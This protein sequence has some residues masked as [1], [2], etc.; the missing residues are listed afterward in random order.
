MKKWIVALVAL[1]LA[2]C[3]SSV[4]INEED[5]K[6]IALDAAGYTESE[7][8]DLQVSEDNGYV[9]KYSSDGGDYQ[10]V[11]NDHGI[12]QKRNVKSYTSI[13]SEDVIER[14]SEVVE[15][16]ETLDEETKSKAIEIALNNL[17]LQESQVENISVEE[18]DDSISVKFTIIANKN[19]LET[20]INMTTGSA[21]SSYINE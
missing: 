12:I 16:E 18:K 10:F 19:R 11:I 21:V 13:D 7:V 3:Q 9:V 20:I 15:P 5:A 2:G 17:K 1:F 8:K 6:E 4:V 14:K